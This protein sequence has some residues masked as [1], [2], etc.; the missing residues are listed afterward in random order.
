MPATWRLIVDG[1]EPGARNMAL[2]HALLTGRAEGTSPPTLRLYRWERPTL[3][4]GRFQDSGAVDLAE[5][6]RRGVDVVRRPTG[7]RAVLH[8]D[9]VTYSVVAAI[10]D[11]VPRGVVASYRHFAAA[12]AAAFRGLGVEAAV[13]DA[14]RGE[15]GSASCYLASTQADLVAGASKLSGSAQVW[16]GEAVLQHGSFAVSRDAAGECA[17]A[18]GRRV[19]L[20]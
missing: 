1:V 11:G 10:G 17:G 5:A 15:R 13:A 3:T 18:A 12:L 14:T 6:M 4:L 9:E 2:D 7:G 8:D 19:E 16:D 20:R